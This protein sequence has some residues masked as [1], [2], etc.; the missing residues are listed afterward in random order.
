MN[1]SIATRLMHGMFGTLAALLVS[2]Y[3]ALAQATTTNLTG[4]SWKLISRST[5]EQILEPISGTTI[6]AQ[7]SENQ[8]NGSGGC[9]IYR[10]T[11]QSNEAQLTVGSAAATRRA[12]ASEIL[13]QESRYFEVLTGVQSYQINEQ[14]QLEIFYE[15]ANESGVLTFANA[16]NPTIDLAG[17]SWKL[18]GLGTPDNLSEPITGIGSRAITAVFADNRVSGTGSCNFYGATYQTSGNVLTVDPSS[19]FST[20]IGCPEEIA[21]QES[22]YFAALIGGQDY[23]INEQGQLEIS[24]L[25]DSE[26]GL[27][28]FEPQ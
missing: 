28:V 5:A 18:I 25:T 22:R 19:L 15:T 24:Y 14:G 12:C 16:E 1:S 23:R 8:V 17:T 2:H 13:E 11:Y 10:A 6:T 7:F 20:L 9:N 21:L 3:P 27:L 26:S 4:T